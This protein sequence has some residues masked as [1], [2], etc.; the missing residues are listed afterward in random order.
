MQ[1]LRRTLLAGAFKFDSRRRQVLPPRLLDYFRASINHVSTL[2][3]IG[4]GFGD[5]HINQVFREWLE[6]NAGRKLEVVG[7]GT[8]HIPPSLLHLASQVVLRD[9]T[10]TEY[11]DF[12]SG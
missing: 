7:S 11:L 6:F 3:C 12:V 8:K 5:T 10:A 2:I 1:F 9:A 4:Y